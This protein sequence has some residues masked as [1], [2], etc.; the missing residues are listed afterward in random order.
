[1][2]WHAIWLPV[3]IQARSIL[4]THA[5]VDC[6]SDPS[7]PRSRTVPDPVDLAVLLVPPQAVPQSMEDLAAR[8]IHTAIIAT[9]GFKET[10]AEGAELEKQ[11]AGLAEKYSIRFVGP[12]CVGLMN[13]HYPLNTTFLQPPGPPAGEIAF[14]S[15]SGAI[16]AAVIDWIRGQGGGLSHLISLGNQ[17]NVSETDMLPEVARDPHTRV[18]TLYIE[19]VKDGRKFVETAS[20]VTRQKPVIA[21]KVGRYESGKRAAAS[22]TGA[23][24]GQETAY[25]VAF[26]KSGVLR[27]D[28]TE[29]MF[30]WAR[31]LA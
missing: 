23:L 21:L 2:V 1:M 10:G 30:Q 29:E 18:I 9:G 19:G 7:T 20:Q 12:N 24:A 14:I 26:E 4:S 27:A 28:T 13:T 3:V 11:V 15:H 22:H 17:T 31:A 16:C 8:G 5:E 6:S 25:D